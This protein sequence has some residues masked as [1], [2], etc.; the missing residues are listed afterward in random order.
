M[1]PDTYFKIC[2]KCGT[3]W[4]SRES[5]MEDPAISLVGYQV[6]F[7]ELQLGLILFNHQCKT[8]IA[9]EAEAFMDLYKGEVYTERL[10]GN[11]ECPGYCLHKSEL[12]RC[13]L[14]CE[15]ASVREVVHILGN[16]PKKGGASSQ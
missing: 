5:F 15:C 8:T 13:P 16:W 11:E 14:K 2:S 3:R 6:N 1:E 9:I 12:R 10:T 4:D 7:I